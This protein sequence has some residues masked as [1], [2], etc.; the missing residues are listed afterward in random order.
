LQIFE[1]AS[2]LKNNMAKCSITN[3]FGAKEAIP[4]LQRILGCQV[5]PFPICYLGLALSTTKLPKDQV[6][7]TVGA[8]MRRLPA[9][10]GPLMAKSGR[11]IWVKSVLSMIPVYCMI[12]DGLPPWAQAEIDAI[13]RRFLWSGKDATHGANVWWRGELAP[14]RRSWE[15]W[16]SPTSGWS[17]QPSKPSGCGYRGPTRTEPRQRY[18]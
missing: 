14:G 9:C 13:C 7:R 10:H 5:A 15:G 16:E 12:A 1:E 6:R 3:I 17:I 11:L 18:P 4:E 8:V 2:G